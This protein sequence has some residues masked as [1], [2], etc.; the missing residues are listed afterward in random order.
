MRTLSPWAWVVA[1]SLLPGLASAADAPLDAPPV[2]FTS[3]DSAAETLPII[4]EP[5]SYAR[6]SQDADVQ[7]LSSG[8]CSRTRLGGRDLTLRWELSKAQTEPQRIDITKFPNGFQRGEYLTSGERAKDERGLIFQEG[9]PGI[10]YYWRLLTKTPTGWAVRGTGR[11]EA[12]ICPVDGFK[13]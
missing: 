10:F 7:L 2:A 6:A 3:P 12:P 8:R 9:E 4:A 11:V 1:L 5:A 13:E